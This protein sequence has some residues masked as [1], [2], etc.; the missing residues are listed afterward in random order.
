MRP[1]AS[2]FCS[3]TSHEDCECAHAGGER[4][5]VNMAFTLAVGEVA[6]SPFRIMDEFDV[7]MDGALAHSMH[8]GSRLLYFRLV[9]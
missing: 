7:F 5:Y 4:S 1:H 3:V 2:A 9:S 6:A 8:R